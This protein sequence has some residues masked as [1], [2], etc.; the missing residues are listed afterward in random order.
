MTTRS[1]R[2]F[3]PSNRITTMSTEHPPPPPTLP[4][5]DATTDAPPA[6]TEISGL[7]HVVREMLHS[8]ETAMSKQMELLE[9][10]L[11]DVARRDAKKKTDKDAVD[12]TRLTDK[13]DVESYL[14]TFER[15][16]TAYEIDASRWVFKLAPQLTGKAQEAYA[17]LTPDEAQSYPA[18]KAAILRRY[19]IN[20]ET[21]RKRFRSLKPLAGQTPTEL[22]TRLADLANKWLKDCKTVDDVKDAVVK[23]QL[24]QTLPEEVRV[25]V[26]ERKPKSAAEAGQLAEDYLQ[27]R[28]TGLPSL[29]NDRSPPGPCPRCGQ[30]GHWARAC[31]NPSRPNPTTPSQSYSPRPSHYRPADQGKQRP[32]P[33]RTPSDTQ[34][35]SVTCFNCNE[36]GHYASR[37]PRKALLCSSLS[38]TQADSLQKNRVYHNGTI[39]GIFCKDILVDTGANKTLVRGDLVQPADVTDKSVT[40]H[41]AHG[42]SVSYPLARVKIELGGRQIA[43]EAAVAGRLPVPALLG[44]DIPEFMDLVN[45][46]N[47]QAADVLVATEPHADDQPMEPALNS[48]DD[49]EPT[50]AHPV[51]MDVSPPT[52]SSDELISADTDPEGTETYLHNFDDSLFP[53]AGPSKRYLTRSQ[54]RA[55]NRSLTAKD[56]SPT[57]LP[58]DQSLDI[59]TTELQ[60][61]QEDDHTLT[62]A[63]QVADGKPST[64][65]GIGFFRREGI[66]YRKYQ[67]PGTT[68]E[69]DATDQLVLPIQCRQSV[70]QLAHNIPLAGHLGRRKTASRILQRFYWPGIFRDV[71]DHCRS[72]PECQ[73]SSPRGNNKAPLVPL[74]VIDVP[75]KRIAMDIVGPLPRSSSGNRFILVICDYAS[76]YPEAIPLRRIDASRIANELVKLF[77]RVGVPEEILTDQG[78]NFTSHLLQEIYKLL[79]IKPIRTTPYH[80]QTDGLVERFNHTLKSML[81]KTATTEGKNW[82]DL[83]PY[84]LFAYREV[85][86]ASTGFS[87]F[88][89]L[90]GRQVRGPLD[91]L[92]DSWIASPKTS[93][94]IVSYV[95]LMQERLSE[96]RDLVKQNLQHAQD[97]QKTWYDK[98]ARN[99]QLQPGDHVLVLLPTSTNKLLAE[100]QGPYV[101]TRRIGKVNYE[102]HMPNRRKQKQIFHVNML[103]EWV[104]PTALSCYAE[105]IVEEDPDDDEVVTWRDCD[106]HTSPTLGEGLS[107][108]QHKD[109]KDLWQKFSHVLNEKP[110]RTS[111][112]EHTIP[113]SDAKPIH[114][115]PYLIPHA[116]RD[117]VRNELKEM[118]QE[119]IIERSS[120]AWASP[121][122]MVKKKDGTLRMCVDYRRLNTVSQMD[123]YPMPRVDELI[124]RLGDASFITT[125]D[126]SRGYWQVP[127]RQQDQHKTAFTTPYGLFQF[128]VMPFG[129]QGAPA[130]FQRMMDVILQETHDF[131]AAYLD[132]VVIHSRTWEDHLRHVSDILQRLQD[133]GLT[134]KP[135]KCQFAMSRCA[136]LGHI[137]EGCEVRPEDVKVQAV[138][139]FPI[140]TSKKQVRAFLGLTGYY[141]RFMPNYADVASPITDLTRKDTPNRVK[142]TPICHQAFTSLKN[143]LCSS[144][145]LRSPDFQRNFILQTDASDRGVGAVL[146]Q[147]DD[148]GMDYPIAYFSKKLLPREVRYSTVEKECLAIKLATHAFRVYLLGRPFI[149]QTDHRSLKWLDQLKDTNSRL[150]RWSLAL[151]PYCYTVEYRSGAS[152]GNADALSRAYDPTTS[153]QEKE[154]GM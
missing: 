40:I 135:R 37:C 25:W 148:D 86:Q 9:R 153:S 103:R 69:D 107:A 14:T 129:L 16:M 39:N 22:A 49:P 111:V 58:L 93:E 70:L 88:E 74:P 46:Q 114:L 85:P 8:R 67:P 29:S 51:P 128:R 43:V 68:N 73:K 105:D 118:E 21:Y 62:H 30:L 104:S 112:T 100:W 36:K 154:G 76:R 41:C 138:R 149:I 152:N 47:Q 108:D 17:A 137:V 63:R 87:P 101:V 64:A 24:L 92:R 83:L 3:K 124:D 71:S 54:K 11:D 123:A 90:Y 5:S 33:Q 59:S 80:P 150:T 122:V 97:S 133:A 139:D 32:P 84:L 50:D 10:M 82:D 121:I 143:A 102:I 7:I 146:S 72:C 120:S 31:Q 6:A 126:L 28:S 130:T 12:L 78:T 144:P 20:E 2:S 147:R 35:H 44:W 127:V 113:T 48:P 26:T 136:Y 116:Y 145:V 53:S 95:L 79:R 125:L 132:D 61:I 110:G 106:N 142:W 65:A 115:P 52:D 99:R 66:L 75:F 96:L 45:H 57:T 140:P 151:Q 42:D 55:N 19:N 131:A 91:I 81:R 56:S 109:V 141:R 4:E 18:V 119:G 94:S 34:P 15:M 98:N 134:V 1:G 89:L 38:T 13:D 27:A 60:E 117:I 77:A 23:E